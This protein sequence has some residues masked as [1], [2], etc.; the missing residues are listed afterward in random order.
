MA[1][2]PSPE[3]QRVI[4]EYGVTYRFAIRAGKFMVGEDGKPVRDETK[5]PIIE[6]GKTVCEI[7]DLTTGKT[8]IE[9]VGSDFSDALDDAAKKIV[10]TPKPKTKTQILADQS[11]D[12]RAASQSSV[13]ERLKK[14]LA[15]AQ[16][17]LQQQA[18]AATS[19]HAEEPPADNEPASETPVESVSSQPTRTR[20]TRPAQP[21]G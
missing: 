3:I 5:M 20:R 4:D 1:F 18:D 16:R 10:G 9:G 8:Y 2:N 19:P 21:T 13:I 15:E 6:P 14:E 12:E 7:I 11:A 17:K